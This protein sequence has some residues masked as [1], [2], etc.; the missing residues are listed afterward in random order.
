MQAK[1]SYGY[2]PDS[3]VI[4]LY[5]AWVPRVED[6]PSTEVF[7]DQV[8]ITWNSADP[9][10]AV[11]TGY[12]I[13]LKQHDETP[14][15]E[16]DDVYVQAPSSCDGTSPEAMAYYYCYV[17]LFDTLAAPYSLVKGEEIVAR[18]IATN[19]YGDSD[20]SPAG[21]G[22]LQQLVPD[23][24]INLTRDEDVTDASVIR[25]TWTEGLSDGG[26]SVIDYD[27]YWDQGTGSWAL[28]K[29]D[30]PETSYQTDFSIV[31]N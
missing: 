14:L 28:L 15:D 8:A 20:F 16:S 6:P 30:V 1:N 22:A 13:F 31:T 3:A 4:T 12:K 9:R 21:N 27:V 7:N 19:S 29:E 2:S 5:A 17:S 25:F 24:P 11:V 18:I 23:A 26:A 10:G